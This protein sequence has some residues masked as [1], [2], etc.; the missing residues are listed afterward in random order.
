[1]AKFGRPLTPMT[2]PLLSLRAR[3]LGA[4][5]LLASVS[6][7]HAEAPVPIP[8]WPHGAP[9]PIA[10]D[11]PERDPTTAKDGRPGGR[12][13]QRLTN[14]TIPTLSV[15]PAAGAKGGAAIIVC[16]GGGYRIL[17][18]DLEGTEVCQWLNSIG[19]TAVLLKYR[20]PGSGPY[21]Q[22]KAAL[23]DAQRAVG[24]VRSR[25]AEWGID[26][27][28]IGVLGFSAGGNLSGELS[29]HFVQRLYPAVDAADAQSCRPDFACLIY[30]GA[31]AD[32][33]KPYALAD[34]TTVPK[35]AP[36]T[37]LL[38]AQ[39]DP[40]HVQ[41]SVS[42]FLALT[43]AKVPAEMHLYAQGGHGYGLRHT[44][45]PV[46]DWPKLAE[47]WLRNSRFIP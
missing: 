30:P 40:V 29:T 47:A 11:G 16:P 1:M 43:E 9:D 2:N 26:P 32:G 7:M 6:G 22:S 31:L 33:A 20:V 44:E 17:A 23:E 5:L 34:G 10:V 37:F 12:P 36:P 19:V 35:D 14:V 4:A 21:P 15:Y 3:A 25:A 8:L 45:R 38:Q 42:Y 18:M 27:H 13:V 41:N 28:R 24:L 46:T 39:D